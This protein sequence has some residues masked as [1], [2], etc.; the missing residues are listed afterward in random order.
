MKT[1]NIIFYISIVCLLLIFGMIFISAIYG[2]N[3]SIKTLLPETLPSTKVKSTVWQL[4]ESNEFIDIN[5][6]YEEC[7]IPSQGTHNENVYLQIKNKTG[8]A[9]SV[10]W[11]TEYWYNDKCYGCETSNI[12]NHKSIYLAPNT[13]LEGVCTKDVNPA[14]VIFSKMLNIETNSVLTNFNLRDI[15][16]TLTK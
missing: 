13:I 12:E 14:L 11:N 1:R 9:I 5:Y 2:Q 4:L 8:N 15:K 16:I 3:T 10:E 6:K 7:K